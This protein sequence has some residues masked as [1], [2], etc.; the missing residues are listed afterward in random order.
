[1]GF[2]SIFHH[3]FGEDVLIF[4]TFSNQFNSRKSRTKG[5]GKP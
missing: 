5:F 4:V 1:M 2:I 3:Q